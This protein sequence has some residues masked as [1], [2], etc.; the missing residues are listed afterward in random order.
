L[1]EEIDSGCV[2]RRREEME[3]EAV[4]DPLQ[5]RLPFPRGVGF[6]IQ[7]VQGT[8]FPERAF[9]DAEIL[10]VGLDREGVGRV[11]LELYGVGAGGASGLD[12]F[13]GLGEILAMVG[14][15]L[16]NDV[17]RLSGAD[18]TAGDLHGGH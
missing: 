17:G 11:G 9:A 4:C 7:I 13:D 6:A 2:E 8:A 3:P 16:G 10:L 14:G 5:F 18:V 12:D 1:F 15:E